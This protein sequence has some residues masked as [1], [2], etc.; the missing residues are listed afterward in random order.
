MS[1]GHPQFMD[2][3]WSLALFLPAAAW[4][5][6][7]QWKAHGGF[8]DPAL[9]PR[10]GPAFSG[11]RAVL[12]LGIWAV[13][14][15]LMF[16]A[17]AGPL[18]PPVRQEEEA[19][20]ADVVLAVDVSASMMARDISPDRLSAVK[21][22]LGRFIAQLEGDR[23]GLVAFAGQP[24]VACPLTSDYETAGLFLDKLDNDSVPSDGTS[25]GRALA[26][27]LDK[28][29]AETGRGRMIVVATDGEETMDSDIRDQAKRA[30][31]AGVPIMTLGIGT[32]QGGLIPGS[33]DVFGRTLAK[34]WKGQ[35]VRSVLNESTLKEIASLSHGEYFRGDSGRSLS[36]AMARLKELKKTKA[37]G[38]SRV[39]REAL[40]QPWLWWALVLLLAEAFVSQ[41]MAVWIPRLKKWKPGWMAPLAVLFLTGFSLDPGRSEYDQGNELYRQGQ[42]GQAAGAY[43]QSL[44]QKKREWADYNL[45]NARYQE[46]DYEAAVEAYEK[47]LAQDPK[48]EDA[49]FNLDLARKKLQQDKSQD[50]D[51]KDKDKKQDGKKDGKQG[52]GDP[53]GN[54]QGGGGQK[55]KGGQGGESKPAP[56]P[57]VN[58]DE[59]QAMM[60]MLA[61]DQKRYEGAFQP[62]KKRKRQEKTPLEQMMEQ[63]GMRPPQKE[64]E[65]GTRGDVKDW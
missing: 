35:P 40:Y 6:W 62:L 60:N 3:A 14:A 30:G 61:Q 52:K 29:P 24:V 5:L 32:P 34:T 63:M 18:G 46:G 21:D 59:V 54:S 50:K 36:V 39:T 27:A 17:L 22:I 12:R 33:T 15:W 47:A 13:A 55:Q 65:E 2:W 37:K 7:R 51:G 56:R 43:Q 25:L 48:D 42:Y 44:D 45:G 41:R 26:M 53:Q 28:F 1:L 20:G 49:A 4:L 8:I 57:S 9:S 31:E 38:N 16:M 11:W 23:V 10:F 58:Q 19:E 64:A